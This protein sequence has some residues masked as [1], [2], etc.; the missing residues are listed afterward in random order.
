MP[1]QASLALYLPKMG[2]R[3]FLSGSLIKGL[4]YESISIH[5]GFLQEFVHSTMAKIIVEG[6]A[7]QY[8]KHLLVVVVLPVTVGFGVDGDVDTSKELLDN[9]LCGL[10]VFH[11][12][13]LTIPAVSSTG[14]QGRNV[15]FDLENVCRYRLVSAL[16][17]DHQ[18]ILTYPNGFYAK[19]RVV[20]RP[21]RK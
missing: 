7:S 20:L 4:P 12:G 15:I 3:G 10:V 18:G 6:T 16:L 8:C 9:S 5:S 2:K 17:P 19:R 13:I 1:T 14:L 11:V 21:W